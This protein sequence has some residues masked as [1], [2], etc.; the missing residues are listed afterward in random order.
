MKEGNRAF[1]FSVHFSQ[2]NILIGKF[3]LE[4][5]G[6]DGRICL[7]ADGPACLDPQSWIQPAID[8]KYSEKKIYM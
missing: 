7:D 8:E 1:N 3:P 6:Q 4:V 5:T 2:G